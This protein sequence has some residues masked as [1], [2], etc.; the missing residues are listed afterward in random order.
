MNTRLTLSILR[1][2]VALVAGAYSLALVV[3]QLRGPTHFALLL[4]GLAELIAAA[5]F[6]I[7]RTVRVGGAALIVVFVI[8][9]GFHVLHGEYNVAHLAVYSAAALTV[10]SKDE[11][12]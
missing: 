5:L 8:A 1:L 4:L 9:A 3:A 2:A 7:P 6:L 11:R 10:I 12:A